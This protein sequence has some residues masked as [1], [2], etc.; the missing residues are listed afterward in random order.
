M[1][2][3][4]L[5]SLFVAFVV[6]A[7]AS[8][9]FTVCRCESDPLDRD[10]FNPEVKDE[11]GKSCML[12]KVHTKDVAFR[13]DV[14]PGS[15]VAV[16]S[17]NERHP[18]ET[19]VYVSSNS[20][21]FRAIHPRFGIPENL[22]D[23]TLNGFSS[24]KDLGAPGLVWHY[25]MLLNRAQ[26]D[27]KTGVVITTNANKA[28]MTIDMTENYITPHMVSLTP[29][30]HDIWF[31]TKGYRSLH[32]SFDADSLT[33]DTTL[34]FNMV[35]MH[36]TVSLGSNAPS[37]CTALST[38]ERMCKKIGD[39][40]EL[41][42]SDYWLI[43]S[44]WKYQTQVRR[45]RIS[46]GDS[47]TINFNLKYLPL[48]YFALPLVTKPSGIDDMAYGGMV[49][50]VRRRGLYLSMLTTS[51]NKANG[52]LINMEELE[53]SAGNPYLNTTHCYYRSFSGGVLLRL[54]SPIHV[55]AG[56]GFGER[57]FNRDGQDG[58]R[59]SIAEDQKKGL[60]VEGGILVNVWKIAFVAGLSRF[61]GVRTG[62][63]GVGIY[64]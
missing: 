56:M 38:G 11:D 15:V 22:S 59:H 4:R 34:V 64:W 62:H 12:V 45:L 60:L 49:G 1:L 26:S 13:Y 39:R 27:L 54:W 19:W 58:L 8:A 61:D 47:M 42:P 16:E 29:G 53:Y 17:P 23:E 25:E 33:S 10:S 63:M 24:F 37:R 18:E 46:D 3:K 41:F 57:E 44:A 55:Y 36:G 14:S 6:F 21:Y 5:L 51:N 35:K 2:L 9:Q 30:Q 20:K 28:L 48:H 7:S 50:F 40:T 52:E 31:A 32:V 43:A